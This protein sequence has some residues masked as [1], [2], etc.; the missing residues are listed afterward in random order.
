MESGIYVVATPIGNLADISFRALDVLKGV[1]VIAAEDTRH[2]KRLLDHYDISTRMISLH[3]H[4]ERGRAEE[5]LARVQSGESVALVSDAGTPLI[6]DPG[7]ILVKLARDRDVKLIPVPGASAITAVL[8]VAG[9]GAGRFIFEGF[10]PAKNKA[11]REVLEVAAQEARA[12]VY[13]ESPHR[14]LATLKLMKELYPAR[15]MVLAREVTKR[16]ETIKRLPVSCMLD[17]VAEDENQQKGEFV[18]VLAGDEGSNDSSVDVD[19]ARVMK[20]LLGE[21]PPKKAAAV[22]AS[23]Y[24]GHKKDYYEE[25]IKLK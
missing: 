18:L 12:V 13:Y 1:D 21:L 16:F 2:T 22:A 20:V 14:L 8:S 3:E 24:G 6:S 7:H 25:A 11:K 19:K 5:L 23:L 4:N 17:W 15:E 10:L 9:I